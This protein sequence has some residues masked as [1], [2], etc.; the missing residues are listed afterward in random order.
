MNPGDTDFSRLSLEVADFPPLNA[1]ALHGTERFSHPFRFE[2]DIKIPRGY[3]VQQLAGQRARL[4]WQTPDLGA[5]LRIGVITGGR[6]LTCAA[7]PE[8]ITRLYL[9]PPLA[10]T[11]KTVHTRVLRGLSLPQLIELILGECGVPRQAIDWRLSGQYPVRDYV[12]QAFESNFAFLQRQL[13]EAGVFY[14][15]EV[16]AAQRRERLCV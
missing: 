12:L 11:G 15:F 10:L 8:V 7:Q 1:I 16:D 5:G 6:D 3:P 14:W 4:R 13:A 2:I 9:E